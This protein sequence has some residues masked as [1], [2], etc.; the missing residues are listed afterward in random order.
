MT[1]VALTI[2]GSDPSGGAGLQADLKTFHQL[3]CYGMSVVS[4]ITVQNTVSVDAVELL[5]PDLVRRQIEAVVS[6]IPPGAAKTGALGSAAIIRVVAE[7][8]RVSDVPLVVDPVMISKHGAELLAAEARRALA[9]EL[10]PCCALVTPNAPEA[11]R[12]TG[13]EVEDRVGMQAA[14]RRL[15]EMGAEAALVKG[16]HVAG[17]EAADLLVTSAGE[18]WLAAPRVDT[19]HTH[20]TGCATAA[21]IAAGLAQGLALEAAVRRAKAFVTEA[22]RQAPGLG[23]GN[24]PLH[25]FADFPDAGVA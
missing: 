1:P 10:L 24:G 19:L 7:W 2:A 15:L 13:L 16:G 25:F 12:L 18:L 20:G 21:A 3:G 4:L 11:A 22:I 5:D 23:R 9:E 14:G 8:A 6:D 17:D